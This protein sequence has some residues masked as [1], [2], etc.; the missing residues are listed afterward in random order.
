MIKIGKVLYLLNDDTY[1]HCEL[2]SFMIKVGD[3]E[4]T[5][6]PTCLIEQIIIMGNTTVSNYLIKYCSE[7][8]ILVSYVSGLGI[9]YGG[10]RGKSVGNVLLRQKQYRLHDDMERK[11][12]LV[13]NIVLGKGLNQRAVLRKMIES[14][15]DVGSHKLSNAIS[16]IGDQLS[17]LKEAGSIES[18]RGIEG[19]IATIYFGA[20]D[21]M[22][23][24]K[25]DEMLFVKRSRRPP[26][27]NCNALLSFFYT[28]ITLNCISALECAG[29]DSYMGYLHELHSGRE[30]LALD[31]VEEFRAPLVDHLIITWINRK[32]VTKTD[33]TVVSGSICMKDESKRRLLQLWEAEKEKI[34]YFPLYKEEVPQK[35]LPYLQARLMAQFIRGDIEEYPP[36]SWEG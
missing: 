13:R 4:Q 17:S 5:R 10:L 25:D 9:Y 22:L 12:P 16:Q 23:K 7:N 18:I 27:N 32:Q 33:F 34:V 3:R 35:L 14:T 30:S 24:T 1:I 28:M 8:A 21:D 6:I 36:W 2:D 26:E 31:L 29:L 11:L 19:S 15:D 20:F